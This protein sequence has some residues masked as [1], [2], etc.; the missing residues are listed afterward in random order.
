MKRTLSIILATISLVVF[1]FST[2]VA[3]GDT[4][5]CPNC[6]EEISSEFCPNDGTK[7]PSSGGEWPVWTLNGVGA[8]LKDLQ[9]S[10]DRH[11]AYFGPAKSYPG[12]GAY[13]PY[14]VSKLTALFAEGD[15]VLVDMNYLTAGKRCVYFKASALT[16]GNTAETVK[17]T[18]YPAITSVTL[19]PKCGPGI[20][21]ENVEQKKESKYA[22]W[23]FLDLVRHFGSY[24]EIYNALQPTR[25]SVYLEEGT[26]VDVFFETDGWVFTEFSC[27]M[28]TIRAWLPVE[29]VSAQ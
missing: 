5:T 24:F 14:K 1:I 6:G 27:E 22:D 8:S 10:E 3:E 23:D 7:K 16:S 15:F 29:Y 28:G 2:V 11:Q 20:D 19:I 25:N 21:Y 17:L 9:S 18:A 12:A 13:K 26:K 4:W